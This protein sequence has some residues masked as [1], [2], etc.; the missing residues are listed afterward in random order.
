MAENKRAPERFLIPIEN[1]RVPRAWSV[2]RAVIHPGRSGGSL[3]GATPPFDSKDDFIRDRVVEI[4]RSAE[5]GSI[6]EVRECTKI[7]DAIDVLRSSLDAL[8]LFQLSRR[9]SDTTSFGLAGDLYQSRIEYV[10]TWER[11]APGGRFRGDHE[12][13]EFDERAVSDWSS[14]SAFQFLNDALANPE[15]DEGSRRASLGTQLFSRAATEHRR[16]LKM[17]GIASALEAWLLRRQ[18]GAQTFRLARHV[19]W[20]ACGQHDGNLCGR[21]RPVC[22][23]LRLS[24]DRGRD[25]ERLS[26]LRDLG[27]TYAAW[28]CSEWHRVM[29]AYDSR[30]G[31]AQEIRR[32]SMKRKP[33]VSSSGSRIPSPSRF[34]TGCGN[35]QM[36]P[37][38]TLRGRSTLWRIRLVG[39]R[40]LM[41]STPRSR[42]RPRRWIRPPKSSS[43]RVDP[44]NGK[45]TACR[46][47]EVGVAY[48]LLVAGPLGHD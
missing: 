7:D 16:D 43:R 39:R 32:P 47:A 30:S 41:R 40:C 33:A 1:L 18:P 6:G 29:D 45:V 19:S 20:F 15:A 17:I 48:R 36:I 4:L 37:S 31:A 12:G 27:N 28:R 22:P 25:R 34:S 42:R 23:Y 3:I 14:S 9:W 11:S 38:E 44:G 13:W 5:H 26:R 24:P 21:A 2:G 10:A 8:R 46:S 35:T